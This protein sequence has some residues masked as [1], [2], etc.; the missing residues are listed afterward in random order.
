MLKLAVVILNYGTPDLAIKAAESVLRQLPARSRLILVDN[1]SLDDSY[2]R[3]LAWRATLGAA[4][5]VDIILS[6]RNGGYSAGNNLGLEA[7]RAEFYILLNSDAFMRAGSVSR[8]LEAMERSTDVGVL[9]PRLVGPDSRTLVSRFR[10]P[11][12]L[13]EFVEA[14]G[15]DIFY[16]LFRAHV[17]PIENNDPS[18]EPGWIGF[19]CIMLR[20]AMIDEIGRLDERYFMYFEDIAY[21]RRAARAGWKLAQE[22]DAVVDHLCGKSSQVEENADLKRRLPAY[23]YASRARFYRDEYGL[24][25][26]FAANLLWYAGRLASY[27]RVLTLRKPTKVCAGRAADIWT[28]PDEGRPA[29]PDSQASGRWR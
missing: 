25:G 27:L 1:A 19:P 3:F 16:R 21:C 7:A 23:Y 9:G 20:G 17:T 14:S 22:P 13:T 8:L 12:P 26:F 2:S 10:T 18:V 5:P 28:D 24:A 11:T 6:P 15:T 29:M 4:A